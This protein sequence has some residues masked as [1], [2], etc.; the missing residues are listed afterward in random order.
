MNSGVWQLNFNQGQETGVVI[1][2]K[3]DLGWWFGNPANEN[4]HMSLIKI[5][6]SII[7]K[8]KDKIVA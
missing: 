7:K 8:I 5:S 2:D 6:R 4:K 3:H 1:I